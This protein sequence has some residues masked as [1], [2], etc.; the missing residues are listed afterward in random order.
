VTVF[1][2][3]ASELM[4][5][6]TNP[7]WLLYTGLVL[8]VAGI[9]IGVNRVGFYADSRGEHY[10]DSG[11]WFERI[12]YG[13][14]LVGLL[15]VGGAVNVM[16]I[17]QGQTIFGGAPNIVHCSDYA[18]LA[19]WLPSSG[20]SGVNGTSCPSA[21]VSP[22]WTQI[23]RGFGSCTISLGG[24]NCVKTITFSPAY[25]VAPNVWEA[26]N[27]T[28]PSPTHTYTTGSVTVPT[29]TSLVFNTANNTNWN[30]QTTD[31]ELGKGFQR[32]GW[33]TPAT[34]SNQLGTL[35]LTMVTN[36][37][38]ST[39]TVQSST[40]QSSW[41]NIGSDGLS[42]SP[43][44]TGFSCSTSET[45]SLTANTFYYFRVSGNDAAGPEINVLGT[46][47]LLLAGSNTV[48]STTATTVACY[49]SIFTVSKTQVQIAPRCSANV[50]AA[51][52][53]SFNWWA[54]IPA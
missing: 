8:V 21:T 36:P 45:L 46:I 54:G 24:S 11:P 17:V 30:L 29:G 53:F 34:F 40:D 20:G 12:G 6:F 35:C 49:I 1:D 4:G 38:I 32:L 23:Q 47:E 16:P 42:L 28:P 37:G 50:D 10:R 19:C 7:Y 31:G 26:F 51:V 25:S 15:L 39:F 44:S 41:S 52:T 43:I 3:V 33:K 5:Y 48:T 2:F 22:C 13:S 14:I 9:L 27:G 18:N